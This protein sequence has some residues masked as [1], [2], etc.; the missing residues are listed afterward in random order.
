VTALLLTLAVAQA[1]AVSPPWIGQWTGFHTTYDREHRIEIVISDKL[2][3]T[4][5]YDDRSPSNDWAVGTI[6]GTIG[7]DG[8]FKI[9]FNFERRPA[10]GQIEGKFVFD[11]E[12]KTLID[13]QA[14]FSYPS[15]SP[16]DR[17]RQTVTVSLKVKQ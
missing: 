15:H 8:K 6:K 12:Q 3:I 16:E 13:K 1:A 17:Q 11:P 2:K 9:L 14:T 5:T 7:K 4:G 10:W